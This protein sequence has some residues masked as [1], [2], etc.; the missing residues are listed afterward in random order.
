MYK[1]RIKVFYNKVSN[2]IADGYSDFNSRCFTNKNGYLYSFTGLRGDAKKLYQDIVKRKEKRVQLV[3]ADTW[4]QQ[5]QY[6][7]DADY[8]IL[9]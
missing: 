1:E 7:D 8:V 3:R 4:E 2:G 5:K 9:A 6:A